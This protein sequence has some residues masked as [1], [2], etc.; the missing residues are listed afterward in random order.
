MAYHQNSLV[1]SNK[2]IIGNAK[3][4]TAATVG[5]PYVNLGAGLVSAFTHTPTMYDV[6]AGNAP[7]PIEGVAEEVCTLDFE[8]IEYDASVLSAI[9]GG[10]VTQTST[11]SLSTLNAGGNSTITP[12]VFR[13]TNTRMIG[14]VTCE[15]ILTIFKGNLT[16]GITINF[17]SDNDADPLGVIPGQ[18]EGKVDSTLSVGSQLFTI[19]RTLI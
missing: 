12:R 13:V 1:D 4:E 15:T 2:L 19:T 10:L 7:D 3:I 8:L 5:G 9:S 18:V 16:T 14:A 6:Q 17:K 11:T